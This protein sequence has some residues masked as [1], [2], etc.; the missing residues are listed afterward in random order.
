MKPWLHNRLKKDIFT[1]W[2]ME[3]WQVFNLPGAFGQCGDGAAAYAA[4]YASKQSLY[5]LTHHLPPGYPPPSLHM[6]IKNGGLGR[7]FIERFRSYFAANPTADRLQWSSRHDGSFHWVSIGSYIKQVLWPSPSRQVPAGVKSAYRELCR[8]LPDMVYDGT[9]YPE[10]ARF[11]ASAL[12]PPHMPNLLPS[13]RPSRHR[14]RCQLFI[15]WRQ[16]KLVEPATQQLIRYLTDYLKCPADISLN[17]Y[18]SYL[19]GLKSKV[20]IRGSLAGSSLSAISQQSA[21]LSRTAL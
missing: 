2:S 6:S 5:K 19:S 16:N 21:L 17:K 1:A 14:C 15:A 10:Y 3:S 9:V 8:I 11:L 18:Y 12:R 13:L 20:D 7:P 4:K